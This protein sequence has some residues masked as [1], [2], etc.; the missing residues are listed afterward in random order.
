MPT[1][2][3]YAEMMAM[4]E[5]DLLLKRAEW[6]PMQV[7]YGKINNHVTYR[8]NLQA[9]GEAIAAR[10]KNGPVTGLETPPPPPTP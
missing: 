2:P 5:D 6:S 9:Y 10:G 7:Q 8:A 1:M 4:S 3:T